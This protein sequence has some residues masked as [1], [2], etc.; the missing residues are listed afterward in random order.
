LSHG[1]KFDEGESKDPC[2]KELLGV[3]EEEQMM[4]TIDD[5][6]DF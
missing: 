3:E 6:V 1:E 5:N 4:E 2:T